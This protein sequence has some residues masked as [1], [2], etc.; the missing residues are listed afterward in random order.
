[1]QSKRDLSELSELID[2]LQDELQKKQ[3]SLDEAKETLFVMEDSVEQHLAVKKLDK[4]VI[5][6]LQTQLSSEEESKLGLQKEID[7]LKKEQRQQ[8]EEWKQFQ[9]DLQMAVIIANDMKAG[10]SHLLYKLVL[11]L[12]KT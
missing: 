4:H 6:K 5:Q 11:C 2:K 1:M 8:S 9:N 12:S 10:K 7:R 3:A